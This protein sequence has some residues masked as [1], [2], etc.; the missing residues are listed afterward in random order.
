[1]ILEFLQLI[2]R[3]GVSLSCSRAYHEAYLWYLSL[4]FFFIPKFWPSNK[5]PLTLI[6]LEFVG[7]FIVLLFVG[8]LYYS[9]LVFMEFMEAAV[10]C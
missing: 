9:C 3:D 1:M 6:Y 8:F 7:A 2:P 4:L 10:E 5:L